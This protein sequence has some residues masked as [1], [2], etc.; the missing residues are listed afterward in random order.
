MSV[1]HHRPQ[2]EDAG[3]SSTGAGRTFALAVG[4]RLFDEQNFWHFLAFE[5]FEAVFV[6]YR[7]TY[8]VTER[9]VAGLQ[10]KA[11]VC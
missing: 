5:Q 8:V 9:C 2:R 11:E 10:Q 4:E 6:Q 7:V 1:V 3:W